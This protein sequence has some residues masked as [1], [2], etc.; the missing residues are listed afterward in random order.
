MHQ[1]NRDN[2]SGTVPL[3][4]FLRV[5][6]AGYRAGVGAS[7]RGDGFKSALLALLLAALA[8]VPPPALSGGS[9]TATPDGLAAASATGT[10][11]TGHRLELHLQQRSEPAWPGSQSAHWAVTGPDAGAAPPALVGRAPATAHGDAA[12]QHVLAFRGRA[13]PRSLASTES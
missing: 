6:L 11:A 1:G 8:V 4:R 10:S 12:D 3:T 2:G 7:K 5:G 13:P 9:R